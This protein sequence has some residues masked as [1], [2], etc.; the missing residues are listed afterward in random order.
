MFR[1]MKSMDYPG[2][3][4]KNA[5][6]STNDEHAPNIGRQLTT[7]VVGYRRI[8]HCRTL[9]SPK[10]EAILTRWTVGVRQQLSRTEREIKSL[11]ER[12]TA[13]CDLITFT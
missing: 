1:I 2:A 9:E 3:V 8:A 11:Q 7:P 6:L 4:Y 5:T 12:A 10:E 13:E